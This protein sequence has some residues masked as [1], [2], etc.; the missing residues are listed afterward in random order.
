MDERLTPPWAGAEAETI[1]EGRIAILAVATELSRTT[2]SRVSRDELRTGVGPDGVMNVR[3]V[4]GGRP[5]IE[6]TTP[7]IIPALEAL[8]A[9][10]TR[11][12]PE[13][14]LRWTSKNSREP[15]EEPLQ[16]GYRIGPQKVGQLL[17]ASGFSRPSAH[18]TLEG[19]S[20][21]DRNEEFEF[22]N[23]G[24]EWRPRGRR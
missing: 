3:R 1:G 2:T 24:K 17:N 15:A 9:P 6:K 19:T 21:L 4:R 13:P 14:L 16:Q 8:V 10:V 18:K 22:I 20:H 12:D 7:E 11:G 5:T 23:A